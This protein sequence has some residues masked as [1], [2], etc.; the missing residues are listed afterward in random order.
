[1]A[2]QQ[3]RKWHSR[4]K[5]VE[6]EFTAARKAADDL[7]SALQIGT[8][9][10]PS[11][12]KVRDANNMSKN[13]EGTYLI[14]LFAAFEAGL[15][16]YWETFRDTIPPSRDLLDAI[17][18]KR[19]IPDRDR[20]AV[21]EVREYRNSLVHEEDATVD[22]ISLKVARGNLHAYFSRLPE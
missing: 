1:M 5:D 11:D 2:K 6:R 10:L 3:R 14:R 17:A 9:I 16:S 19:E 13:L 20:D 21:H 8:A 22:P 7:L 18:A 12:T 15:R 4:I